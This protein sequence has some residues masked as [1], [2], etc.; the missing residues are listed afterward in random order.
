LELFDK[1]RR[2]SHGNGYCVP[3]EEVVNRD[4]IRQMFLTNGIW[5]GVENPAARIPPKQRRKS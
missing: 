1:H 2:E 5:Q 4:G 3:P